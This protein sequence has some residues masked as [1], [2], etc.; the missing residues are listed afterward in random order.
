[1]NSRDRDAGRKFE[2]DSSKRERGIKRKQ[3]QENLHGSLNRYIKSD[4]QE[5][6]TKGL[7]IESDFNPDSAENI[8]S[9]SSWV[10]PPSTPS[11]QEHEPELESVATSM[12]AGMEN[13]S[14]QNDSGLWP[15][16]ITDI[17]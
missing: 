15:I 3:V 14:P 6:Y 16:T 7:L 10:P 13:L 11:S 8:P 12:S 5:A 17:D 2:S 1:M 9:T 4:D